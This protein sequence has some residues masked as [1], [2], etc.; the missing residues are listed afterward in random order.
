MHGLMLSLAIAGHALP[1]LGAGWLAPSL[2]VLLGISA[3]ALLAACLRQVRRQGAGKRRWQEVDRLRLAHKDGL[4]G[5]ANRQGFVAVLAERLRAGPAT[6]LLLLDMDGFAAMNAAHGH[7]AA[8][9]VLVAVADRLRTLVPDAGQVGRLGGDTFGV[10]LAAG[11]G[12]DIA[13]AA[14][15]RL[16]RG[17]AA[18]LRAGMDTVTCTASLGVAI[19]PEHGADADALLR[20]AQTALEAARAAGVGAWRLFQAERE[21]AAR[22]R[23][24][25]STELGDAL[26]GGLVEPYYQPVMELA[27]GAVAG[28]E[29]LARW[30]HPV[31]GLLVAEEFVAIAEAEGLAAQLTERLMRR[32][33]ADMRDL[34]PTLRYAFNV[35]PGQLREI[36][37]MVRHPPIWP[38][39][40]FDPAR[41]TIEVTER[42]LLED[43]GVMREVMLVLH[44]RGTQVVL[45]DFGA[46]TASLAHLRA[47]PFDAIKIDGA[48]VAGVAEDERASAC[49]RAMLELGRTL[50]I[51]M[52][53][54]GVESE[55][56]ADRLA[57][58]G[59][60][61]AQ[62]FF[63]GGPVP[64][65]EVQGLLRRHA[66]SLPKP[67]ARQEPLVCGRAATN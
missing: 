40:V 37:A 9:E 63:Y 48:F 55:A 20:S 50:R 21:S 59:C 15:L 38:E 17:L 65:R 45:D 33:L 3:M 19:A 24:A 7:R 6:A 58:M 11:S 22:A 13:E 25:L 29:V 36:I 67:P 12:T 56:V 31:R 61:F 18:P 41:I 28:L 43:V 47:L 8:D 1:A 35:L 16:V 60:R 66:G 10:L 4:T 57:K 27:T 42:A 46:G 54:E 34:P 62:G 51:D 32:V 30:N 14:A 49:V 64:A 23:S 26:A 5:L 2:S 44:Q 39:G 53:A 52:V